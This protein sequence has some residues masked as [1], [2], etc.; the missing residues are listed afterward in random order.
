MYRVSPSHTMDSH[1]RRTP[2]V[3]FR[4][5][6]FLERGGGFEQGKG[7]EQGENQKVK[8]RMQSASAAAI[9][10]IIGWRSE[11]SPRLIQ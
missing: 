5:I 3:A 4:R 6:R 9:R 2:V 11:E 7:V 10:K 1:K 8:K